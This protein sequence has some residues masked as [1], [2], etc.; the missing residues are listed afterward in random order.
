MLLLAAIATEATGPESSA[1][2]AQIV[3]GLASARSTLLVSA[4]LFLAA[5]APALAFVMGVASL[6]LESRARVLT[7]LASASGLLGIA[8]LTVYAAGLAALAASIDGIAEHRALV[9]AVFRIISATDD[10]ASVFIGIFVASAA[11]GLARIGACSGWL[12]ILGALAGAVRATG[13][14]DVTTLGA[15]PFA[16]FIVAG[17]ILCLVWLALTSVALVFLSPRVAEDS[18]PI[19]EQVLQYVDTSL[20][21]PPGPRVGEAGVAESQARA[22]SAQVSPAQLSDVPQATDP[23]RRRS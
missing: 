6:D 14:L 15:L 1:S 13:V 7:A 18:D 19:A 3:S 16:P 4:V 17:T 10:G 12:A 5:T 8:M 2:P 23:Y 11:L 22:V 9:Y 20:G 21:G